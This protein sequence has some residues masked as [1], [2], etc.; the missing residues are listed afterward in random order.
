MSYMRSITHCQFL[1]GILLGAI[2][3]IIAAVIVVN[4]PFCHAK[5]ARE[6]EYANEME[7]GV[8]PHEHHA[9]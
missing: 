2:V 3:G 6:E 7:E 1:F 5:K 8:G 9:E 4:R